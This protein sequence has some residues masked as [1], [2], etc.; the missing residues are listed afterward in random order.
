MASGKWA[1]IAGSIEDGETPLTTAY[2]EIHEETGLYGPSVRLWRQGRPYSFVDAD[3]ARE[4]TIYSFAFTI[5]ASV[6][7]LDWEHDEYAW[8]APNDIHVPCVPRLHDSLRAVYFF[9]EP[10]TVLANGL[11][12]LHDDHESGARQLA[13]S[14]VRILM[15]YLAAGGGDA[16]GAAWH[17]WKNGRESMSAAILN[18]M[19]H[20]LHLLENNTPL[21]SY[22]DSRADA[23]ISAAFA[24]YLPPKATVLT[25]SYSSTIAQCLSSAAD[26][27]LRILESR[28]LFEGVSLAEKV[29]NAT[30][31]TDAAAAIAAKGVDVVLLGADIIDGQGNVSNKTGSLPAVLAAKHVSAAKIVV[32]AD[33]DKITPFPVEHEKNDAS[34]VTRAW[35]RGR[36]VDATVENVYFEWVDAALIDAYV[37]ERGPLT[38]ADIQNLAQGV[39]QKADHYFNTLP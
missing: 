38:T 27:D 39:Q 4:W 2:R 8:F 37:T 29:G 22:L 16:V 15:V 30:L 6:V 20:C 10:G 36:D 3:V 31:Y 9:D 24:E 14:A 33:T 35:G 11:Q 21:Q 23:G 28:P 13:S 19:L 5:D 12:S 25:L 18:A 17:L 34:E 26:I 1:P 7:T 32:V